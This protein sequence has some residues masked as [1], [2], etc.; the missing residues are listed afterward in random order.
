[1]RGGAPA[2]HPFQGHGLG[3]LRPR[4]SRCAEK[5]GLPGPTRTHW[6]AVARRDPR[7]TSAQKAFDPERDSFVQSYGSRTTRRQPAADPAGRL[8]AARRSARRRH[9]RGDRGEP[10][11]ATA[12]SMRYQTARMSTTA[13]RRAKAR[14][15]PA[16]SGS[17]TSTPCIG[18]NDDARRAV[19]APAGPAQRCRPARRGIRPGGQAAC[20]A[21]SRRPSATSA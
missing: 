9:G 15:W 16:A 4:R 6:R 12:S 2:L 3:R 20:S 5:F 10:D 11:A 21:I 18:R 7:T 1:M 19:R 14:S 8:P 13:C 17:P